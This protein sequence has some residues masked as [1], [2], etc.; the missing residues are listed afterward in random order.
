MTF[1]VKHNEAFEKMGALAPGQQ[2]SAFDTLRPDARAGRAKLFVTTVWNY[3]SKF[4]NGKR[5]P[6]EIA[7]CRDAREGGLW[8]MV[9]RPEK[10]ARKTHVAHWEGIKLAV[11][12]AIPMM[13]VLKDV[14][15][16]L[17]STSSIFDIT[18]VRY[19]ADQSAMW[20]RLVPRAPVDCAIRII[21]IDEALM[22]R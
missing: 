9:S 14:R 8:Y 19:Q 18:E 4:V 12:E 22:P 3:H 20:L 13:G 7:I 1:N 16:G 21:D 10:D 11:N 6:T 15:T 17:C 5:V 2:W